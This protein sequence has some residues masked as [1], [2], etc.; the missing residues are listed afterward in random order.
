[1]S[2][3]D[4]K[5]PDD[6]T[7]EAPS[8]SDRPSKTGG[9]SKHGRPEGESLSEFDVSY[10]GL[11]EFGD[12]PPSEEAS[13]VALAQLPE[14]PSAQSMT[15]W[16]EVIRQQRA[17]QGQSPSG[18]P[19]KV[20]APSDKDL[21]TRLGQAD[22]QGPP[23][24]TSGLK[25]AGDT[26][27]L[28]SGELG[29][30]T[31]PPAGAEGSAVDLGRMLAGRAAGGSEVRFDILYPPSDAGGAIPLP[32]RLPPLSSTTF[33]QAVA[34]P[35]PAGTYPPDEAIPF[36][37]PVGPTESGAGLGEGPSRPDDSRASILDVLLSE[38]RY[39]NPPAEPPA[40]PKRPT[41]P[42]AGA[43]G[44]A[45]AIATQ[46]GGLE[47]PRR[48]EDPLD[49]GGPDSAAGGDEAVDLYS[50]GRPPSLSESGALQMPERP[51][52]D[53]GRGA[54][55]KE[56]SAVDLASSDSGSVFDVA[57][58]E[59]EARALSDANID[60]QIPPLEDESAARLPK[61]PPTQRRPGQKRPSQPPPPR[62]TVTPARVERLEARGGGR[63]LVLGG[64]LGLVLGAG[65]VLAA[66]FAGVLPGRGEKPTTTAAAVNPA[67]NSAELTRLRQEADAAKAEAAAAKTNADTQL[68]SVRKALADAGAPNPDRPAE[69]IKALASAAGAGDARVQ[70]LT[71]EA[72]KQRDAAAAA[73]REAATAKNNLAEAQKAADAARTELADARK[74]AETAKAALARATKAADD[75]VAD[76]KAAA[77]A[78]EKD[79]AAKLAQLAKREEEYVKAADAAKKA[80]DDAAKARDASEGTLKAIGE[81]LA[82]AKFVGDKPD[83]AGLVKGVDDALKA[84]STDA[85]AGL[86]EELVKARDQEA[87]L[88][89]DLA[90]ARD[91]EAAADKAATAL[92]AEAQKLQAETDRL[93]KAAAAAQAKAE[94]AMKSAGDTAKLKAENE[95]LA[96][97][98]A[99]A[100]ARAR[101]AAKAAEGARAD[102]DRV[103]ADTAR[104]KAENDRLARDLA[105]VKEL[106]EM[107]KS[108]AVTSGGP[109]AKPDPAKLAERFFAEGLRHYYAGRY[110]EAES[111]LRKAIQ[112]N[113]GDARYHYLLG[114]ALWTRNDTAGAEAEFEKGRDA[115]LAGRPSSRVISAMLERIQGPARQAMNA[116]RP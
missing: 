11:V 19:M 92:K 8:K 78:K 57:I 47:H 91:K 51:A 39:E 81:R 38:S 101:E 36:A 97:E 53:A 26:D 33:Q 88:K 3:N 80:A 25:R 41:M 37:A 63:L 56:S 1:M 106:S 68:G 109:A 85:T 90:A 44:P 99:D 83:G 27:E 5:K 28:A 65:A 31:P 42:N 10:E 70:Q 34:V 100:V 74:A 18:S 72:N 89:A 84:V 79:A 30:F 114:L 112:F 107:L 115:E 43:A 24:G 17:A 61:A 69:A 82:K 103:A 40:R 2:A 54:P 52:A 66:Y 96:K 62:P 86:R 94:E 102:A 45:H 4:P 46:P 110:T 7:P 73:R 6:P 20:D 58:G 77:E 9:P 108:P 93:A 55:P 75:R 67:D 76:L 98:A 15:T 16:T 23:S 71:A 12:L 22:A 59:D 48:A 111:A 116:Y 113:P 21:I 87:K 64:A 60:V 29:V 49:L 95:R 32:A 105:A 13:R 35:V 14:P 104:L 50:G